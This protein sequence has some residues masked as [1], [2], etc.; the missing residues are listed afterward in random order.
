MHVN[1]ALTS[2]GRQVHGSG[3]TT[4]EQVIGVLLSIIFGAD[5]H[6]GFH[7]RCGN[8][9]CHWTRCNMQ[10]RISNQDRYNSSSLNYGKLLQLLTAAMK[11]RNAA[12]LSPCC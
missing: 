12:A 11:C 5:H 9:W 1:A 8:D 6:Y 4:E 7:D 2:P 3:N 10:N